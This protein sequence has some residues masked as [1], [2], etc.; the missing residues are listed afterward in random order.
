MAPRL[1]PAVEGQRLPEGSA[2]LLVVGLIGGEDQGP[3]ACANRLIELPAFRV[4]GVGK[5]GE[6]CEVCMHYDRP[7]GVLYLTLASG[8]ASASLL[9]QAEA[10]RR[11]K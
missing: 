4:P 2:P 9:E 1:F 6:P 11:R 5:P 10:L 7:H 3:S 8:M